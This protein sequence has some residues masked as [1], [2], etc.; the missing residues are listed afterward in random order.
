M[1]ARDRLQRIASATVASPFLI[2]AEHV[3]TSDSASSSTATIPPHAVP[4]VA[5]LHRPSAQR[6]G[7]ADR[8][9]LRESGTDCT[10]TLATD[11]NARIQGGRRPRLVSG[12]TISAR[13]FSRDLHDPAGSR[14]AK[15]GSGS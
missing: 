6:T 11:F 4:G 15:N 10:G 14:P 12:A 1:H 7:L 5:H 2:T 13:W 8:G 3:L 9:W